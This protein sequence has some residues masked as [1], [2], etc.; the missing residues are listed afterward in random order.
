MTGRAGHGGRAGTIGVRACASAGAAGVRATAAGVAA[1]CTSPGTHMH[2]TECPW[3]R[4]KGSPSVA[5]CLLAPCARAQ[6]LGTKREELAL[7][8]DR[9]LNGLFKLNETNALVD[10]M[11]AELAALQPVLESKAKATAELL[12][13]V[14]RRAGGVRAG[15]VYSRVSSR[16][17]LP[18][19]P[20]AATRHPLHA[21]TCPLSPLVPS[22]AC[23][24]CNSVDL[25]V[26]HV[27][28]S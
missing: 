22:L 26:L 24:A 18:R 10:R 23:G 12:T 14:R 17:K 8:K 15:G 13:K 5:L 2:A 21:R 16:S 27:P 28:H 4:P 19:C 25:A 1:T 3:F 20:A 6:L 11:K 9:L 7:A